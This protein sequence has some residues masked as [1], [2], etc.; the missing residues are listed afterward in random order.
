MFGPSQAAA[1]LEG[2]K[3]FTKQLC[4]R[5][6]IPTAGYAAVGSV[7]AGQAALGR[8]GP[9]YVLKADGLAGGKGVVIAETRAQ[10]ETALAEL[11]GGQVDA[12]SR[13][14]GAGAGAGAGVVIE[15]FMRGEE[16]SFFALTDGAAI[17]PFGSAQDHKRA[18]DGDTGPNTG[19]MGAYSPASILTPELRDEVMRRIIAPTVHRLAQDG[20]P[21]SGVLYAGLMLTAQGPRLIEYNCRFG[22]PE[23]QALM[24]RFEG[25]LADYLLACAEGRLAELA[26][27]R[28]TQACA[29]TVVMAAR[30]YPANPETGGAIAGIE[31]AEASGAQVFHAAT[32]LG[33]AGGLVAMGGRVLGVTAAGADVARAHTR[34]Y[35]AVAAIDFP[36]G[37]F[38]RDIGWR[39]LAR[40]QA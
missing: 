13:R 30:G 15:E 12:A 6:G 14:A 3:R 5:A 25:D 34:A 39:E 26:P 8:F 27:A 23:C 38:R 20:T 28:F 19:G 7:A 10:A 9:P 17:L 2:S 40:S 29:L 21:Y 22:D 31:L 4:D 32:A 36:S 37:F 18:F 33:A 11:L 35:A 24:L 16:V 1:R